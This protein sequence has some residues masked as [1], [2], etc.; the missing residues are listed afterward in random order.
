[1]VPR[2]AGSSPVDRPFVIPL[3]LC[4]TSLEALFL[5][6]LQGLTEFLPV[7]SSGHLIL[8]QN[9]F[10]L[11][12]LD[13]LIL[14]DLVIHLGTL[15]AI[16]C[17]FYKK[18]WESLCNYKQMAALFIGI[19]PL[20]PLL[21]VIKPIKH[22]FNEPQYLGGFFLLTAAILYSGIRFSREK[23]MQHPFRDAFFIGLFQAFAILPGVSRSGS[24]IS[25]A[26]LLGWN[27]QNA[28]TFSFL[29]A[30]PTILGGVVIESLQLLRGDTYM[31]PDVTLTSY[32]IGFCSSFLVGYFS[33][34]FLIKLGT[35]DKW[36]IF[37]WYCLILGI[38]TTI[39]FNT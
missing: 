2:V 12:N 5:G 19:L 37:V 15:A 38:C 35:S 32:F 34:K 29:L 17:I 23:V 3:F 6:I 30:I 9:L 20:F 28:V 26:R 36:M 27:Y 14:F 39:H 16:F 21:L 10:G 7:S 33:L 1:M 25:G 11:K 8:F 18:I 13:S 4:M 24:T 22:L 31:H